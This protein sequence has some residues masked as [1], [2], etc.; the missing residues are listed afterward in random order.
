M[1]RKKSDRFFVPIIFILIAVMLFEGC[2][3]KK[4][5]GIGNEKESFGLKQFENEMK[6]KEYKF[7]VKNVDKDFLP[8]S[9][10]RMTMEKD[11]ID[12]YIYNSNKEVENDSK[13]IG[14]D[15]SNY[16]NGNRAVTVDWVSDPHFYKKGSIIVQ[17]IG[18]NE[19]IINDLKDILGNQFAGD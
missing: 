15:G 2:Q 9:R 3:G 16:S 12:I 5:M 4:N 7:E 1:K 10:K 14:K 11:V 17:Y 13:R 18:I 8:A 19:K 6:E